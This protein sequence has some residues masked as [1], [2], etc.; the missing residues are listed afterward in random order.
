MSLSS[1]RR[2]TGSRA[3]VQVDLVE[4]DDDRRLALP[5]L[6]EDAVLE[7][8]PGA[9]L[10]DEDAEVGAVEDLHR[11]LRAQLAE[12]ADVV[13]AGRVDEQHRAERQEL[14][15]LLDRV[16]RRAGE[17]ADDGD[18]LAGDGVEQAR[19]ADV[20]AAEDADVEPHA[21]GASMRPICACS[22]STLTGRA[23]AGVPRR[24]TASG[25]S[26]SSNCVGGQQA[27]AEH[28]LADRAARALR[29]GDDGGGALVADLRHERGGRRRVE[30]ST[31]ARQR[32]SS[33]SMPSTQL[34]RRIS[35]ARASSVEAVEQAG[36]DERQERVELEAAEAGGERRSSGRSP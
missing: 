26:S 10:G 23:A 24:Q 15:R 31:C 25:L 16:G 7:L 32:A 22:L 18:L 34:R 35:S 1:C 12:G 19:L 33:A 21:P 2:A 30:A 29:L 13:D 14:H 5:E 3:L 36:G 6:V 27:V 17:L 28:D 8:A 4:H 20:A 11:A 9:G